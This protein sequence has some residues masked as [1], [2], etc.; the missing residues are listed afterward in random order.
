MRF[1]DAYDDGPNRSS[2]ANAGGHVLTR[3]KVALSFLLLIL[4]V[5]FTLQNTQVTD[6]NFIFWHFSMSRALLIFIVLGI[7]IAIGLLVAGLSRKGDVD[8]S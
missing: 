2:P 8:R 6:L 5:V 4:V 1:G 3:L 7:G